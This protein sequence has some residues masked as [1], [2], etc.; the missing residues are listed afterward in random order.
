MFVI[1]ILSTVAIGFQNY[2][3][4]NAAANLTARLRSLS[5]KAMLRQDSK[6]IQ[7]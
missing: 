1:A 2:L 6:T 4:A 5:F 7:H 3:F